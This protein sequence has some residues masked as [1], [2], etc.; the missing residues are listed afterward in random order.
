VSCENCSCDKCK[1]DGLVK[2]REALLETRAKLGDELR[3]AQQELAI[4]ETWV[5]IG[6]IAVQGL[7]R[8]Y[9]N[10]DLL[11]ALSIVKVDSYNHLI[12]VRLP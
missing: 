9:R 12:T 8:G 4:R 6:R 11:Q 5:D 10:G 3:R 2:D 7:P 1:I